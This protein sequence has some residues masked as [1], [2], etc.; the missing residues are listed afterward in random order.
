MNKVLLASVKGDIKLVSTS[1]QG[2]TFRIK[3]PITKKNK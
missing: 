3:V 1:E 2:T